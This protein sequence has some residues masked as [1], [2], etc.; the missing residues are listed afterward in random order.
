[1]QPYNS[2]PSAEGYSTVNRRPLDVEDYFDMV[3]RHKAWILGPAFAGLVIA[4]VVACLWPNTYVSTATIRVVP[5][6]VP[7]TYVQSNVNSAMS[8]RINSMYQTVSSRGNLTNIINLYNLYPGERS[9]K[10]MED[11]V[12]D[13]RRAIAIADVGRVGQGERQRGITAFQISFTYENRIIAQKVCA[14]L[15]SRFMTE[16]T[17]ESTQQSIQTTQFLKEQLE[18]AKKEL[19]TI[20]NRLAS[21][22]TTSQGRLPDQLAQNATQLAMHEQRIANLNQAL[23]RVAQQRMLLEADLRTVKSQRASLTPPQDSAVQRQKNER[24]IAAEREIMVQEATLSTLRQQYRDNY[25]EVRRVQAQLSTLKQMR[26]KIAAEE[27]SATSEPVVT[28]RRNDPTYEREL[29]GLDAAEERLDAQLKAT[30]VEAKSYQNEIA[31]A[32]KAIRSV[33]SRIESTPVSE[34]Q[35]SD[36]IR[37]RE[38]AKMR[39]DDMNKKRSQS[40]IAEDLVRRQQGETLELLDAASLPQ[41]PTQPKRPLILGGGTGVGLI[42]GLL[43]AG[44]RE[45]K[46]TSLKNLKDVRAY[47]QLPILGS[48]PLLENDLVVRRRKRLT[49]LA[50]STAC[51]VGIVIMTGSAFYYYATKV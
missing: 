6:Q 36:I 13:M 30:E 5:P 17:R 51:L 42:L 48:V 9:R 32:E 3:R 7:E 50:W 27:E 38:M 19:E 1:M 43:L 20:E 12:E 14:D 22:R 28:V 45:A 21:F 2:G 35:Y 26:D 49:W 34:Q 24:L 46:D 25:P 40:Q 16:N 44:A 31:N 11:V 41:S 33:Q 18:N 47:T 37:D 39:Y 29:R 23:A 4:T 10:P 15:V 8:Q